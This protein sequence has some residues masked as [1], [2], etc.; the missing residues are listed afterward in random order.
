[1]R[2]L[3][4]AIVVLLAGVV[5]AGCGKSQRTFESKVSLEHMQVVH[6]DTNGVPQALEVEVEYPDCPGDQVET[7]QVNA[8]FAKCMGK[9]KVGDVVPATI[10]YEAMP[11]GHYDSE[12]ERLGDCVRHRDPRDKRSYEAVEVCSDVVINGVVA[13]F[14]CDRKPS[15]ELL[16]KCPWFVRK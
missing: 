8:E 12:I 13:G 2:H 9:Y 11:D 5:G 3:T 15:A 6:S 16:A 10:R 1:M 7:L 14:H 4:F